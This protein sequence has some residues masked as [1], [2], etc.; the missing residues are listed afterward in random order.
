MINN[1]FPP[2]N[3]HFYNPYLYSKPATHNTQ[4]IK[5]Y[6][7]KI[8]KVA[9]T[10]YIENNKD[11]SD[12]NEKRKIPADD[13]CLNKQKPLLEF[14]GIKL[15]NDD[16]LILLLIYFLYKENINDKILF[17]VLFSLLF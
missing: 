14:H 3:R 2:F 17:I 8:N 12:N 5:S 9:P 7:E 15:F 11:V 13:N 16:L 4:N 6:E 10:K 1:I